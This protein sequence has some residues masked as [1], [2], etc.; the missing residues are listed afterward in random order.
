MKNNEHKNVHSEILYIKAKKLSS[1]HFG[2]GKTFLLTRFFGRGGVV[3]QRLL[4]MSAI[5]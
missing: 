1:R 5:R 4:V 3:F 2:V